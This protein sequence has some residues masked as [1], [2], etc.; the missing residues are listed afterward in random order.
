MADSTGRRQT[1]LECLSLDNRMRG[2]WNAHDALPPSTVQLGRLNAN[3]LGVVPAE[4][5]KSRTLADRDIYLMGK[6][7]LVKRMAARVACA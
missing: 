3:A 7:R 6:F 1:L 4:L 2:I 5:V